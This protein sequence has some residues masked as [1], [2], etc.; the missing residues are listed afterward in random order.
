MVSSG[1]FLSPSLNIGPYPGDSTIVSH[2][3]FTPSFRSDEERLRRIGMEE[4]K[5]KQ[6]SSLFA[7]DAEKADCADAI[8][9]DRRLQ[10][11]IRQKLSDGMSARRRKA[12]DN[13]YD[14]LGYYRLLSRNV[15]KTEERKAAKAREILE[16]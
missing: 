7:T 2:T 11:K 12:R 10:S 15:P 16:S 14:P 9:I 6:R 5:K 13:A 4:L 3:F 8:S 1:I